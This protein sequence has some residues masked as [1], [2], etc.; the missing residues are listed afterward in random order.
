MLEALSNK[1]LRIY[2]GVTVIGGLLLTANILS[3]RRRKPSS[4]L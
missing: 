2:A 4:T 3:D 1:G